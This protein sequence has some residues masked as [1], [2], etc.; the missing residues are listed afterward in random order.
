MSKK[1]GFSIIEALVAIFVATIL[2]IVV[3]GNFTNIRQGLNHSE[4]TVNASIVGRNVLSDARRKGFSEIAEYSGTQSVTGLES[5]RSSYRQ[6]DYKLN[7]QAVSPD[8][9]RLWVDVTW[10]ESGKQRKL[11]VESLAVNY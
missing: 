9:K 6:Y 11:T 8:K 2:T 10:S 1:R 3:F 7:F 5:N 4:N